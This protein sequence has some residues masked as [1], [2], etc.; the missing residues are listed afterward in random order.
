M[1]EEAEQ[2]LHK[3]EALIKRLHQRCREAFRQV[4][5]GQAA[6]GVPVQ[7]G[8]SS[9]KAVS[10]TQ[11]AGPATEQVPA[12]KQA[13]SQ[14]AQ[15]SQQPPED[16]APQALLRQQRPV[17]RVKGTAPFAVLPFGLN[18]TCRQVSS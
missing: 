8:I 17:S 10:S 4:R 5:S 15:S 2:Q 6:G 18:V 9:H 14:E 7:T 12:D 11:P 16:S 13:G 1:Q 3:Q